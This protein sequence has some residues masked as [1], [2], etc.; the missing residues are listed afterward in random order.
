MKPNHIAVLGAGGWGIAIANL[1]AEKGYKVNLWEFDKAASENLKTTRILPHKLPGIKVADSILVTNDLEDSIHSAGF[2]CFIVP[3]QTLRSSAQRIADIK[4]PNKP[5]LVNFAKGIENNSLKRMSEVM[6][7][8]IPGSGGIATLSGPSH[9]EEVARNVPTAV[10][11]ASKDMEIAK[12]VQNLLLT[13]RFRVYTSTDILGVELAGSL[14]NIIALAAGMLDGLGLGDNTRGAL[15]TRG[16]A[17]MVRMGKRL[18][19]DPLTFSGL[20]GIGDLVTTCLSR[21]SRNRFV[22]EQVGKGRKLQDVLTHMSMVAEGVQST[23]SGYD[24]AVKYDVEMPIT[25]Q[26]YEVLFGDKSPADAISDL[27]SREAKPEDWS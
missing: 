22:G 10:V 27:M 25:R 2:I 14:K 6:A 18:G 24:M 16:L 23:Q 26:V 8:V 15:L 12:A 21:H 4:L 19:A 11:A 3:S 1:L 20:S 5:I 17:E 9:A 7:E 13:P